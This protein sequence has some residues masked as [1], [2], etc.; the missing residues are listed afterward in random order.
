MAHELMDLP[1]EM[2]M[3]R[4][5]LEE[6]IRKEQSHIE[7]G[8]GRPSEQTDEPLPSLGH[9]SSVGAA[10]HQDLHEGREHIDS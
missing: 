2:T 9:S 5:R 1:Y 8:Y 10:M 4:D 6:L 7:Y 3:S